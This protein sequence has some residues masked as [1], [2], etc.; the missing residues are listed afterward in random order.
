MNLPTEPFLSA[1]ALAKRLGLSRE[2]VRLM[3]LRG[4]LTA[5]QPIP[6]GRR[7]YLES[8]ARASICSAAV[9]P[10][11][12]TVEERAE[13]AAC[14]DYIH[15]PIYREPSG[16]YVY[17]AAVIEVPNDLE[18]ASIA[19]SVSGGVFDTGYGILQMTIY[20]PV[21]AALWNDDAAA[22]LDFAGVD[23]DGVKTGL[24][25]IILD[26]ENLG[27]T[28]TKFESFDIG[29]VDGPGFF[30]EERRAKTGPILAATLRIRWGGR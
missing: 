30:K 27:E 14:R 28:V 7:L 17:P 3:T 19:Q 25:A 16:G 24:G 13:A 2:T 6:N 22:W 23:T 29:L 1:G 9:V 5:Y 11:D 20:R 12:P 10:V 15:Y 21:P 18:I 26:L 8:E 4:T